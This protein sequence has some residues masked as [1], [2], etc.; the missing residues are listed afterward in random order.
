[1]NCCCC[2]FRVGWY[3]VIGIIPLLG[4]F[5]NIFI[6]MSIIR[7]C[8]EVDL[9]KHIVIPFETNLMD[10]VAQMYSNLAIDFG[11]GL[12]PVL[13]DFAGA[14]FKCNT[15]NNILLEKYLREKGHKHPVAPVEHKVQQSGLRRWFGG[16][17]PA[18]HDTALVS[19]PAHAT[20]GAPLAAAD[21]TGPT[22]VK[23]PLP[24]RSSAQNVH[25]V[26]GGG[27]GFVGRDVESQVPNESNVIHYTRE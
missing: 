20:T 27:H 17:Q 15:R 21:H 12:V 14:W 19:T 2:N 23:P 18:T 10:K 26:T 13:G 3:L 22:A 25:T 1:M 7:K 4:D 8:M 5:L 11:I 6:A 9:P 16:G 24:P